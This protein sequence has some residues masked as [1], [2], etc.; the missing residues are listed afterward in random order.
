MENTHICQKEVLKLFTK[1]DFENCLD[2]Y[3]QKTEDAKV[4]VNQITSNLDNWTLAKVAKKL[5]QK[6]QQTDLVHFN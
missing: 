3:F 5:Q 6:L 1:R 2:S 4:A